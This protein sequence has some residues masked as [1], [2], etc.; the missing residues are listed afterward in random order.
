MNMREILIGSIAFIIIAISFT[1]FGF[2]AGYVSNDE[3]DVKHVNVCEPE[4]NYQ[5]QDPTLLK[6]FQEF[7]DSRNYKWSRQEMLN[8]SNEMESR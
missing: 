7:L 5:W 4:Q 3:I 6:E 2:I 1:Y 8:M